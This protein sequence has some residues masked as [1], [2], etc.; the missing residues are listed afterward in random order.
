MFR[1]YQTVAMS[2]LLLT[3]LALALGGCSDSTPAPAAPSTPQ[4]TAP[5]Q[6]EPTARKGKKAKDPS[7][8]IGVKE[9]RKLRRQQREAAGQTP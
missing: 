9:M 1:R 3:G 2:S 6:P 4:P 7:L 5:A 8:D